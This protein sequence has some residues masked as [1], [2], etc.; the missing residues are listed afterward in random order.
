MEN[1]YGIVG[2]EYPYIR[3]VKYSSGTSHISFPDML[4]EQI[5]TRFGSAEHNYHFCAFDK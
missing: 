2:W 5:R 1:S 4:K 3:G